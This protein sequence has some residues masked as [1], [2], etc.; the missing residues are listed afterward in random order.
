MFKYIRSLL[1]AQRQRVWF[2]IVVLIIISFYPYEIANAYYPFSTADIRTHFL[3]CLFLTPLILLKS[4]RKLPSA[5]IWCLAIMVIGSLTSFFV[6]GDKYYYHK[7]IH[8]YSA[9]GLIVIVYNAIGYR[10]FFT[11]YNR[12]ILIM[13]ILGCIG[14]LIALLGIPPIT[15]FIGKEDGRTVY[16]WLI[17]FTKTPPIGFIRYAGFFDEPGAMGYW[18]CFALAINRIFIKDQRLERVLLIA[19][20][21][22][23]SMGYIIQAIAYF[24]MFSLSGSR[25]VS[26]MGYIIVAIMLIVGIYG[27][28]GTNVSY[29]YDE[30]IGRIEQMLEVGDDILSFEGTSREK[31]VAASKD[32][33]KENPIWGIGWPVDNEEYIGD[34]YY[35][36]LAHDG[37]VGTIY[38]Y[39]PY[40]LLLFWGVSRRDWEIVYVVVFLALAI[41]HRPIH[42]NMLTYFVFYSL[43]LMYTLKVKQEDSEKLHVRLP[44]I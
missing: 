25:L 23:F 19:L 3:L 30:S 29:I 16:S 31:L 17:T 26:R 24:L 1:P 44:S 22:T 42:A 28:R 41:F 43:P 36:T 18:G 5:L 8:L 40:I 34:N 35:E 38:Q 21:F 9:F 33:F 6:S 15:T 32:A 11:L 4:R 14:F 10:Q 2:W 7:L 37:I 20:V 39:F 27:T 13:A 12:W